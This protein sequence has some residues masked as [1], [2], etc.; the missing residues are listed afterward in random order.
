MFQVMIKHK[1]QSWLLPLAIH[2]D[3]NVKY[4][5][6]LA[7]ATL[8]ANKEIE[9]DV[10]KCETL[11]LVEPFITS[12]TPEEFANS[13]VAHSHGQSKSWLLRLVPV[14]LSK[15]KEARAIAAFHFA[16][17]AGIKKKR[18][19]TG[20]FKEIKAVEAL[21]TVASCPTVNASRYAAQALRLIGEEVPHKLSTQVP[22]WS[23][24]DVKQ[25][26]EQTGFSD[27]AHNFAYSRVD[28]D[29]LLQLND[30]M[31]RTDVGITNGILRRR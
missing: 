14:L 31:L 4:Y 19:Q 28:G 15:R 12:C 3:T 16:M 21:K 22:L 30:D 7:V 17:E 26:V 6:L 24:E 11:E 25:W 27:F 20:I 9:A 13:N 1:A 2:S 29:L 18:R 23:T 8:V 10:Q 5:A